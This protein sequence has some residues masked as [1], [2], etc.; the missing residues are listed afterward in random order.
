[1][2]DPSIDRAIAG[3]AGAALSRKQKF[4]VVM[5]ARRAW[6]R[7]GKPFFDPDRFAAGDPLALSVAE[8]FELWRHE[9]QQTAC[10][11]RHL[12]AASQRE[13]P[14]LMAHFH[15]LLGEM[16]IAERW[17]M[18]AACDPRRQARA[19]LE[20]ELER[21]RDTHTI[22]RPHDYA[23]AIARRQFGAQDLESLTERQL[24]S[25]VFTIRN[26]IASRL[27]KRRRG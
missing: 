10:G 16:E 22:D 2:S 24:W 13:Y 9:Q 25:L 19:K 12:T 3:A 23:L 21:A 17:L 27:R 11:L 4:E 18:R 26:R 15:A 20:R 5:L 8:A 14:L 6:N 7:R 1:M